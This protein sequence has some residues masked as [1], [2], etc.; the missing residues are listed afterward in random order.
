M[1]VLVG[2][3]YLTFPNGSQQVQSAWVADPMVVNVMPSPPLEMLQPGFRYRTI[4]EMVPASAGGQM[5]FVAEVD[6]A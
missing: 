6:V 2:M 3:S 5:T 1:M 4:P